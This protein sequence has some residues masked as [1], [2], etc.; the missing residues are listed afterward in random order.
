MAAH[1]LDREVGLASVGRPKHGAHAFITLGIAGFRVAQGGWTGARLRR[2]GDAHNASL[3]SGCKPRGKCSIGAISPSFRL[4]QNT[5]SH[6][7][8]GWSL[9]KAGFTLLWQR[10]ATRGDLSS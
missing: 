6:L 1:P 9:V 5:L 4:K 2:G 3:M 8:Y 7:Q 10:N